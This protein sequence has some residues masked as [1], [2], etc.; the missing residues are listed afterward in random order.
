VAVLAVLVAGFTFLWFTVDL[1]A[2][3]PLPQAAMVV[4]SGGEELAVVGPDGN[5]FEVRLDQVAPIA[6]QA[7]I[8]AED[9]RFYSHGGIDPIGLTRAVWQNLRSD[10]TQGGSTITQQLVKLLY[11]DGERSFARKAQEAVLATKL[12]RTADKDQI[13]ERYLNV[14]YFGRGAYGIEAAARAYFGVAAADLQTGQAA[15]LAGLIRSPETAEPDEDPTE[16]TR[17]RRTVLDG[18]VAIGAIT[19]EEAAAADAAALGTIPEAASATA[20]RVAPHFVDYVRQQAIEAVGEEA[21]YGEGLRIVTT[22]DL[23][24]QQGA[25]AAIAEILPD[26]ADPQAALVA[27]DT[28]GAVR[29]YVGGRDYTGLQLDLARGV[30]AGG[31][32]RQAGSTFKPFVLSAALAAGTTLD[33]V[34]PAP[35]SIDLDIGGVPWSVDNY[36]GRSFGEATVGQATAQSINT[37]YAQ[38]LQG[39]GPH[40]VVDAARAAGI[41]SELQPDPSIALGTA[42]VSPLELARGYLTFADDGQRVDPYVISRI[43]RRDGSVLWEPDR[44]DPERAIDEGVSRAVT[45]ALRGVIDGGTGQAAAIDRPAAGKTGTT[46]DNADAWFAGYV[47]GYAAVVWMGYPEGSL[48]MDDVH[49]R[50]VTGGS[51]P[52]QIWHR[53]MAVALDGREVADFPEPPDDLLR[54][55]TTSSSST[56]ST[57]TTTEPEPTSTVP[58]DD[59]TST[60]TPPA[61]STTVTTVPEDVGD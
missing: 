13:L 26:P 60:T 7:V 41:T 38:L 58:P 27:L 23:R 9:R 57:T 40:A 61:S 6:I 30:A 53:Y 45:R 33:D 55:T 4:A 32:G 44:S 37:V 2:D 59:S 15:L 35:A 50:E 19:G 36:G 39:V 8:A 24:A 31:T 21:V 47:P 29:A 17:R 52:A 16:A 54:G 42:P 48:P 22:L 28:D 11:T 46:Q 43:E 20:A 1:P 34:F 18:L 14:V 25:E 3:N 56:S 51:F 5:R 10:R 49:G 12:E